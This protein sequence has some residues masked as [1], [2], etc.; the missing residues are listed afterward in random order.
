MVNAAFDGSVARRKPFSG[1]V[2]VGEVF[3]GM[4]VMDKQPVRDGIAARSS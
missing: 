1:L 2:K 3:T 4:Q